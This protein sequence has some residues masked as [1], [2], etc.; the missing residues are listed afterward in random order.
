[1]NADTTSSTRINAESKS[2]S[3]EELI[4]EVQTLRS[5]VSELTE[6]REDDRRSLLILQS[7]IDN[8]RDVK[9]TDSF[10]KSFKTISSVCYILWNKVPSIPVDGIVSYLKRSERRR[11]GK[12]SS[13]TSESSTRLGN[14][15]VESSKSRK[16]DPQPGA[17]QLNKSV[18]RGT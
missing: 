1:M 9:C 5:L 10:E 15:K 16:R 11:A 7:Q 8:L 3:K 14:S 12:V 13:R 4:S 18:V 6:Q 17:F 2:Q